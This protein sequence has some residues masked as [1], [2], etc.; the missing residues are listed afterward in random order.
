M[1]RTN[2]KR[3]AYCTLRSCALTVL[4]ESPYCGYNSN[5]G[6]FLLQLKKCTVL[7]G[8]PV[9]PFEVDKCRIGNKI[10]ALTH[11]VNADLTIILCLLPKEV[12]GSKVGQSML[13][14]TWPNLPR[15]LCSE[16]ASIKVMILEL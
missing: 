7:N 10:G 3:N 6:F 1:S 9:L 8:F 5:R 2:S 14:Q 13:P 12:K 4:V 15:T 16:S 11:P